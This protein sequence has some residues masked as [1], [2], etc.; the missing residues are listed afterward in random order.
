MGASY[1]EQGETKLQDKVTKELFEELFDRPEVEAAALHK[2]GAEITLSDG[3]RYIVRSDGSWARVWNAQ[4]EPER[5][6]ERR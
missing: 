4:Q 2:P 6:T 5:S 3:K 1:V